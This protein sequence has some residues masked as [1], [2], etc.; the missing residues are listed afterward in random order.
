MW[1]GD[2]RKSAR[3]KALIGGRGLLPGPALICQTFASFFIPGLCGVHVLP[4]VR[5]TA[6]LLPDDF[7][8]S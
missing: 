6:P 4:Q 5:A 8:N 3:K 7:T 1:T 2:V